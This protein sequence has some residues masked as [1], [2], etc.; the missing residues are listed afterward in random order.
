MS[1]PSAND[2][3]D[4]S[5]QKRPKPRGLWSVMQSPTAP[6]ESAPESAV[7]AAIPPTDGPVP[8]G[9]WSMMPAPAVEP[10]Q[11]E[12]P[13]DE[14]EPFELVEE[15]ESSEEEH[16]DQDI[17]E[18]PITIST[19]AVA[20]NALGNEFDFAPPE[21]ITPKRRGWLALLLGIVALP[22]AAT[23]WFGMLWFS[24][25]TAACGFGALV[26]AAAEWTATGPID[27]RERLKVTVGGMAGALALLIGP[28]V[29]NPM[30]NASREARSGR[31]TQKHLQQIGTAVGQYQQAFETFP[32]GGTVLRDREGRA[33]GGHSWMAA[34][35]PYIGAK[36][37]FDQ[38]DFSQAYDEPVNHPAM[39]QP[40]L[41]FF[42]AGGNRSA[43]GGGF[44]VAHF[45]GVGGEVSSPRDEKQ[46]A[47]VFRSGKPL[48]PE[49]IPDGLATTLMA[50]ELGGRYP[51]WGDTENFRVT[52]TG[53][54]KDPRGFGN[55]TRTGAL[56]LFADGHVKFF[57][58]ATDVE[59]LRRLSTRNAGDLTA[60]V[61]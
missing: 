4:D 11:T 43:N 7:P 13:D 20:D 2:P 37:I 48:A 3:L 38:I 50:G 58:N 10:T 5:P 54:N 56:M 30:G 44:A 34:L 23:A 17:V 42:A 24:L 33:R 29:F 35:L 26:L 49:D 21:T 18:A 28:Y 22:L 45:S 12:T 52:G 25:I 55:A 16:V 15:G 61:E 41:Q 59:V 14:L 57:P 39:S 51:A 8:R 40:I 27:R 32:I 19:E 60:G 53:L 47:G 6:V 46:A 31:N 1:S 36:P 9:L